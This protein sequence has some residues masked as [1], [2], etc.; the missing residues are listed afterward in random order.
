MKNAFALVL[1]AGGFA[2][3]LSGAAMAESDVIDC[4]HPY[5]RPISVPNSDGQLVKM[6]VNTR[7]G[8]CST[9]LVNDP[10]FLPYGEGGPGGADPNGRDFGDDG[11]FGDGSGHGGHGGDTGG[12]NDGKGN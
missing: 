10:I 8:W 3:F 5:Q 11:G 12:S 7:S 4:T 2:A 9:N 1:A 6:A